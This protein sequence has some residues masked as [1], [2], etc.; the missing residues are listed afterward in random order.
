V[1]VVNETFA[2]YF[3]GS[4]SPV[5][6]RIRYPGGRDWYQVVGLLRDARHDGLDLPVVPTVFLPY[7]T[8]LFTTGKDDLRSLRL[9]TVVLRGSM[10]P[11]MLVAPVREIVHRLNP[12]VPVYQVQ[13]MKE[14]LD[15]SLWARRGYSL[16]FSVFA[17]IAILLA[18]S[19]VYGM[20]S[21]AVTQRTPEI[22]VRMALGARPAQVLRQ[23]LL[24]GMTLV[25]VG[26][27]VGLIGTLSAASL[28]QSLLF[29][30][31]TRDPAIYAVVAIGVICVGLLANI[32][33]A[34]RAS[35]V[36]PMRALRSD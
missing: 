3:W 10:D 4:Q 23:V 8:A 21:Y 36:D 11:E 9:M 17:A 1:V 27:A 5:G 29:G 15:R 28:L 14:A 19:G 32:A 22:G 7:A 20:I 26:I 6:R 13:T 25:L 2:K 33:P 16:A 12:G 35:L 24:M 18:V 30:V 34:L 31:N